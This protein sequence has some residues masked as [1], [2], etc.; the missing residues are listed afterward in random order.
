MSYKTFHYY[1][2]YWLYLTPIFGN[3]YNICYKVLISNAATSA[4]HLHQRASH[5]QLNRQL[6]EHLFIEDSLHY[7]FH[8]LIF[9]YAAPVT[10][11]LT[12]IFL[13]ALIH[14]ASGS[15]GSGY[16]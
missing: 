1:I 12:P 8:S 15:C 2:Y 6:L 11:L 4:L 5:V 3:S 14:F 16:H 7:L 10:L 13:F 9:L